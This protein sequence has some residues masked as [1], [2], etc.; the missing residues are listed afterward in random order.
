M[1][2]KRLIGVVFIISA[3]VKIFVLKRIITGNAVGF[4]YASVLN[5]GASLF[6]V[7]GIVLILMSGR[8]SKHL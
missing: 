6:F 5:I 1:N 8:D 4:S 7:I 3:L 2:K